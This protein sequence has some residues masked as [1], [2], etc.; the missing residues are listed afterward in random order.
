LKNDI[1]WGETYSNA[2]DKKERWCEIETPLLPEMSAD[3]FKQLP[4]MSI[5]VS[6]KNFNTKY[7]LNTINADLVASQVQVKYFYCEPKSE[8]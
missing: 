3:N 1:F 6:Q 4:E 2:K 8:E 5:L 7:K